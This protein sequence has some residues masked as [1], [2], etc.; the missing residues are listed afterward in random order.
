MKGNA[1]MD[2]IVQSVRGDF[3]GFIANNF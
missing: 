3:T 2:E 1:G